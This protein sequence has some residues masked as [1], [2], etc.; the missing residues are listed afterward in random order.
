MCQRSGSSCSDNTCIELAGP[1]AASSAE[2]CCIPALAE[3]SAD[4]NRLLPSVA[5]LGHRI[6]DSG[7]SPGCIQADRN[8]AVQDSLAA[9]SPVAASYPQGRM[10]PGCRREDAVVPCTSKP[11]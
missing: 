2:A 1:A 4:H 9:Y 8:L 11:P 3:A 6:L 10:G 5:A 7:C